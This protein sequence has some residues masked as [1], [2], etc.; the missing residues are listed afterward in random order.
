MIID[1]RIDIALA[2]EADGVHLGQTDMPIEVARKLL[3]ANTIIGITC[4]THEEVKRAVS[5]GA[6]YVGIGVVYATSTK[7]VKKPLLGP[8]NIGEVL[9]ALENTDVKSVAI[10]TSSPLV[11]GDTVLT[12]TQE[13]SSQRMRSAHFSG[14]SLPL[15]NHSM[16]SLSLATSWPRANP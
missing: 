7:V 16:V 8:R 3:P 1:D 11:R 15:G 5:E 12:C 13:V 9:T 6:D 4:S 2:V 14:P 10:G